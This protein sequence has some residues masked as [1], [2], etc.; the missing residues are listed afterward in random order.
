MG[1]IPSLA[2]Q[3]LTTRKPD[4]GQIEVAIAA[5]NAAIDGDNARS[6]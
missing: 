1:T 3:S 2:L 6:T 5:M 4:E